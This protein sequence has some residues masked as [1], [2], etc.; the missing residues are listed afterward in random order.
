MYQ[1]TE[2]TR[3]VG[4]LIKREIAIILL[5]EMDEPRFKMVSISAVT[6]S[7]DLR[8]ATIFFTCIGAKYPADE[9]Q[10]ELN[11]AK[12]QIRYLLSSRIRLK[13]TTVINF[14]VD[15]SIERGIHLT[16]LINSVIDAE[17]W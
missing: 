10:V 7:R 15:T 3:R 12:R 4:E 8:N 6:I 5:Q 17:N 14:R 16:Q 11:Q 13:S 9:L 2:R 1:E